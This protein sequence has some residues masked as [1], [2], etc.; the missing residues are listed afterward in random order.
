M[1][2][3]SKLQAASIYIPHLQE[4][5]HITGACLEE[6]QFRLIWQTDSKKFGTMALD[7]AQELVKNFVVPF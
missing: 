7:T 3:N 4:Y 5:A 6:G 2:L 1:N